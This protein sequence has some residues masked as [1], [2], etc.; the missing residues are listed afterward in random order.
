MTN[1]EKTTMIRGMLG[2][3]TLDVGVY[4]DFT[5]EAILDHLYTLVERPSTVTDVP[6]E[7][8]MVQVQAVIAG[9]NIKGGENESM[10]SENGVSRTFHFT[11][12]LQYIQSN[13]IPYAR[14]K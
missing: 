10:H 12:C 2:D 6:R 9:W 8:E 14:I 13:V 1:A 4:L 3:N 11:D 5:K 7:Y